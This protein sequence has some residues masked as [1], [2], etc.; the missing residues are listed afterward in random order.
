MNLNKQEQ[1]VLQLIKNDPSQCEYFF[2]K[3]ADSQEPYKWLWPLKEA[4]YFNADKNPSPREVEHQPGFFTI[5]HWQVLGYLENIAK[6]NSEKPDQEIT[7]FLVE[8]I[9][10]IIEREEKEKVDNWRTN[11][12]VIKLIACL[13]K[14]NINEKFIKFVG[15]ISESKWKSTLVPNALKDSLIPRLLHIQSKDLLLTLLEII[16]NYKV[17]PHNSSTKYEPIFERYWL[18]KMLD[19]HKKA[20]GEVCG[21]SSAEIG[22]A[23]IN[24]LTEKEENEFSIWRVKSIENHEQRIGD[25]SYAYLIVD[26]VRD[27]LLAA[28]TEAAKG[29]LETLVS[30]DNVVLKRIA[31]YVIN[32]RYNEFSE[33]FWNIKIDPLE[34]TE[35]RHEVY[36]LL[37]NNSNNFT[38]VQ[39][40]QLIGWIESKDYYISEE[41]KE[42][43]IEEKT[44]A[45]RKKEWLSTC[46]KTGNE[47]IQGLYEKYDSI[48]P[49]E[50]KHPGWLSWHE[51]RWGC[52]KSPIGEEALLAMENAKIGQYINDCHLPV[53]SWDG[54]CKEGLIDCLNKCVSKNPNKFC[55]DWEP[56]LQLER[57]YQQA[58]LRGF[59]N[60][61]RE[62]LGLSI[63]KVLSFMAQLVREE[64]FWNEPYEKECYNYRRWII[65]QIAEFI[66][67]ILEDKDVKLEE[68]ILKNIKEILLLLIAKTTS[69]KPKYNRLIDAYINDSRGK[70][71]EALMD[72]TWKCARI[73]RKN[74]SVRWEQDI[75]Y[76]FENGL[77]KKDDWCLYV[78]LGKYLPYFMH[79]DKKWTQQNIA[80][81]FPIADSDIWKISFEAYL[82]I[83]TFYTDLYELM[84]K[85]GH[86]DKAI[87]TD[88]EHE[89]TN[90][91]L[92]QSISLAYMLGLENLEKTS[93]LKILL[94]LEKV[95][96]IGEIVNYIWTLRENKYDDQS[97]KVKNLWR[98]LFLIFKKP[99]N[100]SKYRQIVINISKWLGL[101]DTVDAEVE[102]WV[103]FSI[104]HVNEAWELSFFVENLLKHVEKEPKHVADIYIHSLE[105][106]KYPDFPEEK[107]IELV[108]GLYSKGVKREADIICTKYLRIGYKFLIPI[109]NYK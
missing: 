79:I 38:D 48:A 14:E 97:Q 77:E 4:G 13:P 107:I 52:G 87:E 66:S 16:L 85:G 27:T 31:F 74:D 37:Q 91:Y 11:S 2:Q 25:D 69:A 59:C 41:A 47:K 64:K 10:N 105:R 24:E 1:E 33:L 88:F 15:T 18:K 42:A 65:S 6:K 50:L 36:E 84:K 92:V 93:M 56:F 28:E 75:K 44:I 34:D 40:E 45:W 35:Q 49:G 62:K 76:V 29:V 53:D 26:F 17:I 103:K 96:Q 9:G 30:G 12:L 94:D 90:N 89:W 58:I 39:I 80:R 8:F 61:R 63:E 54:P 100:E 72:Y 46:I 101:V 55:D 104:D 82:N 78:T 7:D 73:F 71:F 5:P 108:R 23:K 20:I 19:Q 95:K 3:L 99:E 68:K 70:V 86:Y 22:I 81:I 43:G 51:S 32:Q 102:E 21:I 83:H 67:G 106:E 57:Q 60:S 109:F 98:E